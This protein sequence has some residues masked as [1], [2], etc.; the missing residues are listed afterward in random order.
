M[1]GN[2]VFKV[3]FSIRNPAGNV[4]A[5]PYTT[6][7][8]VAGGSRGD[9][10]TAT[11]TSSLATAIQSNLLAILQAQ[12]FGGSAAPG[13]TIFVETYGHGASPDVWT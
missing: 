2:S 6:N 4:I 1:A 3:T 13:G 11:L 12:G 7:V 9:G 5:G 10:H 8:G